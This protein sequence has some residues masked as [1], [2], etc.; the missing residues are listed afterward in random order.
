M[1]G[2]AN[3][4]PSSHV[5]GEGEQTIEQL[6]RQMVETGTALEKLIG[7]I[8][9]PVID[10][11]TGVPILLPAAQQA[12]LESYRLLENIFDTT[13]IGIVYMDPEFHIVRVNRS[14]AEAAGQPPA[15]FAGKNY[16]KMY[17]SQ[18]GEQIFH[19]VVNTGMPFEDGYDEYVDPARPERGTTYWR[20]T[21]RPVKDHQDRVLGVL[22]TS[23]DVTELQKTRL[24]MEEKQRMFE[25]F[26]YASP[27]ANIVVNARGKIVQTNHQVEFMFGYERDELIGKKIET[28]IPE[29]FGRS[30]ARLRGSYY[31]DPITRP[32]GIG[33]KLFGRRKNGSEFPVD[34]TL[35]PMTVGGETHVI[36]VVRDITR[37]VESEEAARRQS[38]YVRLLQDVA[39]AANESHSVNEVLQYAMD[40][41]CQALRWPVGH[42]I[43]V[44][45]DTGLKSA[46]LWHLDDPKLMD[47][48]RQASEG[49][50]FNT[51]GLPSIV[52]RTAQPAWFE[53]LL[54]TPEFRR[55]AYAKEVGL[56]AAFSFPILA[57]SEVVGVLEFFDHQY[58]ALDRSLLDVMANLGTQLGRV[59]ERERSREALQQSEARFRAIFEK[60]MIGIQIIDA[61]GNI[62]ET[63]PALQRMLGYSSA[64][65]QHLALTEISHPHDLEQNW[66]LLKGLLRGEYNN[67]QTETRYV[68]QNGEIVWT[69]LS[70][71]AVTDGKG[72]T[73]LV[74][75]LVRDI[76]ALKRK[77]AE[78]DEVQ[79]KLLESA[80]M[81]RIS[82]ARE[83]HDGP[84]QDLYGATFALQ[85]YLSDLDNTQGTQGLDDASRIMQDVIGRLRNI[86]GDLRPPALSPFG[87][88][89]AIRSHVE[90]MEV[91]YPNITFHMELMSDRRA[92]TEQ[93]R[94]TL[95]R[96]Y[97]QLVA[98]VIRHASASNLWVRLWLDE[99]FV[100]LEVEDDG[101][102][103]VLPNRWVDLAREGH[104]GLLGI[105]ERAEA[106]GGTM[107][108]QNITPH[109]VLARV[110]IP[111]ERINLQIAR[112]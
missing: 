100:T 33:L 48:F 25:H 44:K 59:V 93:A 77:T 55:V 12:L 104:A 90:R 45:D 53:D 69:D 32:M 30:H 4:I 111:R 71:S 103:F 86:C 3:G 42:A 31:K 62:L 40:R 78:L 22:L 10:P 107:D 83:L 101:H 58:A 80:E 109:G 102:G 28:L 17:L 49:Q 66:K 84:L 51:G 39:I 6:M 95:F 16:V 108:V 13:D 96:I 43:L 11:A 14:F 18:K 20:W 88:E 73:Q 63:N 81:E 36:A 27:D 37:R 76:T 87:L 46:R 19:D 9:A 15:F 2:T 5:E 105:L 97:Q 75:V 47:R 35:S 98:N 72:S 85:D 23:R 82:L 60:S 64:E 91:L 89:K 7:Q 79:R 70:V 110:R 24:G 68:H 67:Y 74:V 99:Q 21:L 112:D 65:L 61:E 29:R 41:I 50:D 38:D 106:F 8:T 26:F 94:L 1:E 56:L 57:G 92:F 34:V 54:H 52:Y